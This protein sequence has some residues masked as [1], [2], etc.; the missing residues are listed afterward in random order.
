ML[1]IKVKL[2]SNQQ[3]HTDQQLQKFLHEV[4]VSSF[5]MSEAR[6]SLDS[7]SHGLLTPCSQNKLHVPPCV[8]YQLS[9]LWIFL[10][11]LESLWTSGPNL[12]PSW[13]NVIRSHRNQ[14]ES[15]VLPGVTTYLC[16]GSSNPCLVGFLC[17]LSQPVLQEHGHGGWPPKSLTRPGGGLA[18]P[19]GPLCLWTSCL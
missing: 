14:F 19:T 16:L 18:W 8:P 1:F 11:P 5:A 10:L 6:V 4:W 2:K 9:W 17:L 12:L 3:L 15:P 7:S 13:T